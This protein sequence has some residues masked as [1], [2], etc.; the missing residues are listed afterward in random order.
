MTAD[1]CRNQ[2][3]AR[4]IRN[5]FLARKP[6]HLPGPL[7]DHLKTCPSCKKLYRALALADRML[8]EG[9]GAP[10][11]ISPLEADLTWRLLAEELKLAPDRSANRLARF[12]W[13][14]G[15]VI[16]ALVVG[17]VLL[18]SLLRAPAGEDQALVAR[19][20]GA[21]PSVQTV[22]IPPPGSETRSVSVPSD[23]T[24]G[25]RLAR[26]GA[27][28]DVC[29]I[30]DT[31]GFT[32]LNPGGRYGGLA[33]FAVD[34]SDRI[35]WYLPN[36]ADPGGFQIEKADRPRAVTRTVRLA[37]NHRPGTYALTAVFTPEPLDLGQWEKLALPLARGERTIKDVHVVRWTLEVRGE[38][39]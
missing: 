5:I 24:D 36:P 16:L 22:C 15:A 2:S 31:L 38:T 4:A 11:D 28:L 17:G 10:G 19:G 18:W 37:V 27:G 35:L 34:Q 21:G 32:Y 14:A 7:Q 29:R 1:G 13:Q 25:A 3:Y 8:G 20:D 12:A 23:E 33:L 26:S 6:P 9:C 39:P 30:D